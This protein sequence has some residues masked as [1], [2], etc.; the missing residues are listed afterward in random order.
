[1]PQYRKGLPRAPL[2]PITPV[3]VQM[4]CRALFIA[5]IA[6]LAAACGGGTPDE[7]PAPA[8]STI[9]A[10]NLIPGQLARGAALQTEI[11]S[12]GH[13]C[14]KVIRTFNQGGHEGGDVWD[15]ECE[16]GQSYGIVSSAD[17]STEVVE[18]SALERQTG[19]ACWEKF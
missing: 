9:A 7:T 5:P 2:D 13:D 14:N 6:L 8:I 17:G 4:I 15:A 10:D 16:G 12:A 18:C 11:R 3:G 1:M 19:T